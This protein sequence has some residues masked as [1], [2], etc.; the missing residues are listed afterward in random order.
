M[1]LLLQGYYEN[2]FDKEF[3]VIN[4]SGHGNIMLGSKPSLF[5]NIEIVGK[6]LPKR[7]N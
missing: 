5:K 2:D 6:N 3:Y 4:L 7:M 1:V